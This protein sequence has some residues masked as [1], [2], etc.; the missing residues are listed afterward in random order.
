MVAHLYAI[1]FQHFY[2]RSEKTF[3]VDSTIC[4]RFRSISLELFSGEL[5]FLLLLQD[6]SSASVSTAADI[7]IKKQINKKKKKTPH[8]AH[9]NMQ[10]WEL[11]LHWLMSA[12]EHKGV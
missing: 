9:C 1:T 10:T 3:K 6:S 12:T 2:T 8:K 4:R 5:T 11:Y 7:Y